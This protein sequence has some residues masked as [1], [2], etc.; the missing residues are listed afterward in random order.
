MESYLKTC[1]I[2]KEESAA[3]MKNSLK[4]E[5]KD[6]IE[7][8]FGKEAVPAA[9]VLLDSLKKEYGDPQKILKEIMKS[10]EKLGAIPS[11]SSTAQY[12]EIS[13]K[14]IGH[15]SLLTKA[16]HLEKKSPRIIFDS[17]I[18]TETLKIVIPK[19]HQYGDSTRTTEEKILRYA[20]VL[21]ELKTMAKDA[22]DQ[23]SKK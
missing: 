23:I 7:R 10:H 19:E 9:D 11:Y 15:K 2:N 6:Y 14:S 17:V 4:G 8:A 21:D 22:R 12:Q 16:L 3:I 18:Y 20:W 1:N 13:M 5:A